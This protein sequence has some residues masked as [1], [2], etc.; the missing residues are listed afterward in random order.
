VQAGTDAHYVD[1]AY[2]DHVYGR[3]REDVRFYASLV[4][5]RGRER[6]L[7]VLELGAGT[8][9]VTVAMARQGAE[10]V[11]VDRMPEMLAR[12]EARL[13]KEPRATR[14]RVRLVRGDLRRLRLS[15]RFDLVVSP[16]NVFMHLYDRRDLE[17]A[18]ETV[19][20]H[21]ARN[22]R[23]VFDVLVPS[24]RELAR[25]P[26][27]TYRSR[28]VVR[29]EDKRRYRYGETFEYDPITQIEMI[30]MVFEREGEPE[31]LF[32]T[33]LAQRQYFP[34]ELEALLHYNGF[35]IETRYGDFDGGPL[36][37]DSDS[38]IILAKAR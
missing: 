37:P 17:Q 2:Y 38:Q 13:E 36:T 19:R 30:T 33:P 10:V 9:R 1:A 14:E 18:L 27:K 24:V 12:A 8:G 16:F 28:P 3:R 21:L 5:E 22:G 26:M 20:V 34:A 7:R 32:I 6:A 15:E 11:G 23:L 35:T 4:K 25:D 31:S 29:P